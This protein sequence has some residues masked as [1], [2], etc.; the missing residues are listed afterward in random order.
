M[1]SALAKQISARDAG[2]F[3]IVYLK[4]M[5]VNPTAFDY[6]SSKTDS[7]A[8]MFVKSP[9]E[10][11]GQ[12]YYNVATQSLFFEDRAHLFELKEGLQGAQQI[13]GSASSE[14]QASLD[15][16]NGVLGKLDGSDDMEQLMGEVNK[17]YSGRI[18]S[19]DGFK[20]AKVEAAQQ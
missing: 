9:N 6:A 18:A 17:I 12:K 15:K 2:N 4:A 16:L 20:P 7:Q 19:P 1:W 11:I 14:V 8:G 10:H 5:N 3:N 13:S